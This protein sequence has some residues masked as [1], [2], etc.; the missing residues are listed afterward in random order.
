[1]SID[2][3]TTFLRTILGGG[4][5]AAALAWG[6][7]PARAD[8]WNKTYPISGRAQV[9]V[10]TNDGNVNV[11]T[12]DQKEVGV[13]VETTGFHISE[14]DVKVNV[15]QD[16]DRIDVDVRVPNHWCVFCVNVHRGLKIDV[17]MPREGDLNVTTGDGHVELDPLSG[18]MDIHTGDGHIRVR[19]AKGEI[20]LRTG[21][22]HIE[23]RELDGRL[24]ASS[25]DGHIRVDGRFDVLN[26]KTGDGSIEARVAAGSKM[27][28]SWT[29]HTGDGSVD[30][31]LPDSFQAD[32]DAHTNDG[33]ISL[34]FP[35]T[36]DGI[37]SKS[38]VRGKINGGGAALT[39][40]TGDGSI[41]LMRS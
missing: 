20:R 11:F 31:T 33:R 32:L 28:G 10:E 26:L 1:M 30:L 34:G 35:V 18:N 9:H 37:I 22:G 19:G 17:H 7:A 12:G 36:V 23:A 40:R 14:H 41:R 25:G 6:A 29:I 16:G 15:R 39:V 38:E 8:E 2:A 27:A 3:Q 5:L 21:D 24:D 13:H 4:L